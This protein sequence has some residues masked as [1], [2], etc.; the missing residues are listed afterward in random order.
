M[1]KRELATDVG[2]LLLRVGSAATMLAVHGL[3]KVNNFSS[4]STKF[5][6]PLTIGSKASLLLAIG[7]EVI[8]SALVILGLGTRIAAIPLWITMMV[9]AFLVHARDP[10]QKKELALLYALVFLVIALLG[11]GR[12]SLDQRFWPRKGR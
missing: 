9:A 10:F 8:C 6:D 7:S 12:Y 4:L 1:N 5:P 11:P 2:L 3:A